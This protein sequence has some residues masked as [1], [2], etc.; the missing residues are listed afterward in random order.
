MEWEEMIMEHIKQ[1][2]GR[3]RLSYLRNHCEEILL[4]AK[5]LS[6]SNEEFL[7]ELLEKECETH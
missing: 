5:H 2:A 7:I 1:L 3:L 4:E 6:K